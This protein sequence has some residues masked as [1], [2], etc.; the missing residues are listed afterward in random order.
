MGCPIHRELEY[1][2]RILGRETDWLR[3][4]DVW[5]VGE[6]WYK[7]QWFYGLPGGYMD[8]DV[9]GS[10]TIF[11]DAGMLGGWWSSTPNGSQQAEIVRLQWYVHLFLQGP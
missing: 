7:R 3:E 1:C 4:I 9:W 8:F 5:M 6:C 11:Y 10:S 2:D